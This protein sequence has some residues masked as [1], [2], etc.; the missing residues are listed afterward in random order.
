MCEFMKF[1][2]LKKLP[3]I[4]IRLC[5][6]KLFTFVKLKYFNLIQDISDRAAA[7]EKNV[8]SQA[9]TVVG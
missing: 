7:A 3:R 4:Q 8:N 1:Y 2:R 6:N 9:L 5:N